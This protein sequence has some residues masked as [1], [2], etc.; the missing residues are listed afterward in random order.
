[1]AS[2]LP[3]G[4]WRD[5]RA[6]LDMRRPALLFIPELLQ[7]KKI[8]IEKINYQIQYIT[9]WNFYLGL[10]PF[11]GVTERLTLR[12]LPEPEDCLE[13]WGWFGAC[14]GGR[15]RPGMLHCDDCNIKL[16]N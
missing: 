9:L 6:G 5:L 2:S 8:K 16:S 3:L 10:E 13:A 7:T 15:N 11:G 12:E 14:A 1:M 4:L